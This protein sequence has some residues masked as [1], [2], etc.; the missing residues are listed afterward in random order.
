MDYRRIAVLH[1]Q[2]TKVCSTCDQQKELAFGVA[3][4][5]LWNCSCPIKTKAWLPT[6]KCPLG[7][8]RE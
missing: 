5:K 2:R 7:K 8:W 3:G 4:C 1:Q 6:S